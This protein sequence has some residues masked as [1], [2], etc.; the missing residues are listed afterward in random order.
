MGP[1]TLELWGRRDYD[2]AERIWREQADT[3]PPRRATS[4]QSGL[5][6]V[7]LLRGRLRD[8]ERLFAQVNATRA[9]VLG[10]TI[11]PVFAAW[12]QSAID[13]E[14]RGNVPR[15]VATLDAAARVAAGRDVPIAT[16]QS[17]WLAY[18]YARLGEPAKAREVLRRYEARLD[19]ETRQL[20]TV[21]LRRTRGAIFL[22]EGRTDSALAAFRES[23]NEADGLPTQSCTV[24]VPL[25]LGFT[26]D[27]AGQP[28][29]ARKY[30]TEYVEM[31]GTGRTFVDR[32]YLAPSLY[33]LGELN[34]A[35]GDVPRAIEYYGRFV[36]LWQHA[37]PEL[38]PRV[39]E[40]RSR[41]EKLTRAKG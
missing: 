30:L 38:Q 32:Y 17:L 2:G 5:V 20:Q 12:G 27:A 24:C 10:D 22:A 9:R 35:A 28:D 34:E 18:G 41:M 7:D 37:D 33:R 19:P 23:D 1:R 6:G 26:F 31:P 39:A 8:A 15:G 16:D 14:I 21:L 13:G 4:A 40:A 25:F 11:D 36:E 29:S 3:A